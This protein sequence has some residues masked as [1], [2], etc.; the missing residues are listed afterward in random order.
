MRFVLPL[1]LVLFLAPASAQNE[2]IVRWNYEREGERI[3][4]PV[5][6]E[7]TWLSRAWRIEQLTF[8]DDLA[9]AQVQGQL[10]KAGV[11]TEPL[12]PV[13]F[14][15]TTPNDPE[16]GNQQTNFRRSGFERAWD[17]TTGGRTA[18]GH[19][20]VIAVLDAGFDITHED[21]SP[22]LWTNPAEIPDDGLDN[23]GN[24]YVD[25]RH[26]W[27]FSDDDPVYPRDPH[28]TQVIGLLGARGDN[29]RGLTGTNWRTRMM[30]FSIAST[31]DVIR[32]YEYVRDQ[33]QRWN[34]TDGREGALVVVTNASF[35][36]EGA[37]CSD[38]PVWGGI[39][40]E[41]GRVGIL[42]AASAA[43]RRWDVD[44][45]GDMPV[46]CPTEFLIGVTNVNE[47]DNLY[48]S[49]A[50]GRASV[51]LATPGEGSYSTRPNNAYAPFS[52]T[53]AAAPYVTG[54]V[55]LLYTTPCPALASRL[56]EDPARAALL[57]RSALLSTVTD[58]PQLRSRTATG[59]TLDVAAA[60]LALADGCDGGDR[61]PLAI[62]ATTPNPARGE[63]VLETNALVLSAGARVDVIDRAGRVVRSVAAE[64]LVGSPIRLRVDLA[65]L[66]GGVYY[67]RVV[68]RERVAGGSLVVY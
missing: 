6:T 27:D 66:G 17:L 4:L 59:G 33:R 32:A 57:V 68:D 48:R 51:D 26:G 39:Y 18:D 23:D 11:S 60:Q 46:D 8:P 50:F 10:K 40:E 62:T 67:L 24:G 47:N 35:G 31:A 12:R 19:D 9:R 63:V 42:T 61:Q 25:D 5:G 21:L 30:L 64:V 41:L 1:L 43:N 2:L 20:I 28:G 34:E 38:F 16:Y 45:N 49:S 56:R 54:A 3:Q 22:N 44:I 36:V 55:A 37:T 65:G 13:T 29:G 53:S 14:R 15:A 58:R 52:G 7:R